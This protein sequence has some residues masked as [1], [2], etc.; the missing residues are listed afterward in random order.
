MIYTVA[1]ALQPAIVWIDHADPLFPINATVSS[2]AAAA[3]AAS[4]RSAVES[5]ATAAATARPLSSST[6]YANLNGSINVNGTTAVA[7]AAD[8]SVETAN[9]YVR[10]RQAIQ[11]HQ[12][13]YTGTGSVPVAVV[14][15]TS[16]ESTT[17]AIA[18]AA[19]AAAAATASAASTLIRARIQL[20][21]TVR[22]PYSDH[23]DTAELLRFV[24]KKNS[25]LLYVP[26]PGYT[27]RLCA[28]RHVFAACGV[29][30]QQVT[31][32][33]KVFGAAASTAVPVTISNTNNSGNDHSTNHG[34]QQYTTTITAHASAATPQSSFDVCLYA[35]ISDGYSIGSIEAAIT[36]V[37]RHSRVHNLTHSNEQQ[38]RAYSGH[39]S[40]SSGNRRSHGKHHAYVDS[41]ELL[42]SL[43]EQP[44][45]YAQQHSNFVKFNN[46]IVGEKKRLER[47]ESRKGEMAAEAAAQAEQANKK[48]KPTAATA[49]ARGVSK[50]K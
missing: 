29:D 39:S 6:S 7:A 43:S 50:A 21:L 22:D 23:I 25:K 35:H 19:A 11:Q 2:A 47:E 34:T 15:S 41:H 8:S 26:L 42:V 9:E 33:T 49:T 38:T 37:L 1:A 4:G 24:P 48:K 45:C 27:D 10:I 5:K 40:N 31:S 3:E 44:Y 18:F 12:Q 36:A 20:I 13:Y 46:V 17:T 30:T 14:N 16:E 28:V 32:M